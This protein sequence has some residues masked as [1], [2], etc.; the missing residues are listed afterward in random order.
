MLTEFHSQ[1]YFH[2][3]MKS[4][5]AE[6]SP[7]LS[8]VLKLLLKALSNRASQN[9]SCFYFFFYKSGNYI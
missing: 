5:M 3:V 6:E 4:Y 2:C 1:G 9:N 8:V 7:T